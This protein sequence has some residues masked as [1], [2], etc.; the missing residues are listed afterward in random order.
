MI[1]DTTRI[2]Q[3]RVAQQRVIDLTESLD[4]SDAQRCVPACPDWTVRQLLSHM[5]G[6]GLDVVAGDQPDDHNDAWTQRQVDARA[7]ADISALLTE[8]RA[9]TEPLTAWMTRHD[10]R[11]MG[12]VVI[13]EQDLRGA[14]GIPGAQ[15]TPALADLR[16]QFAGRLAEHLRDLPALALIGESW[17]WSSQ[18]A[19]PATAEVRVYASDFD[20]TRALLS[21][22]SATQLRR[23]TSGDID[24]YLTAFTTLGPLPDHDLTETF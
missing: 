19:D 17:S 7:D 23:W 9:L 22:R 2:A 3:W 13:H 18:D 20:L 6:L 1:D 11:P 5:V 15:H 10:T 14:L 8:W 16:D 24:P 4:D 21:R 12:D